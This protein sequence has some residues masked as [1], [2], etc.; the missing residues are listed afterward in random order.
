[1]LL[2]NCCKGQSLE[3]VEK[4]CR[5]ATAD[6]NF[7]TPDNNSDHTFATRKMTARIPLRLR[8]HRTRKRNDV[9]VNGASKGQRV[10]LIIAC[11]TRCDHLSAWRDIKPSPPRKRPCRLSLEMPSPPGPRKARP[12]WLRRLRMTDRHSE[13]ASPR[14][15]ASGSRSNAV[16]TLRDMSLFPVGIGKCCAMLSGERRHSLKLG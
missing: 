4:L 5:T 3:K 6:N 8:M 15:N 10:C 7:P 11:A 13:H 14:S 16:H 12:R 1:M 2:L 9:G